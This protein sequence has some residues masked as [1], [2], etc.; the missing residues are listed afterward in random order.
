MVREQAVE[1]GLDLTLVEARDL[2]RCGEM[3]GGMWR[4]GA[5]PDAGRGARSGEM[6][7]GMGLDLTLVEARDWARAAENGREWRGAGRGCLA[8]RGA[9][10]GRAPRK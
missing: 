1:E 3:W 4:Y 8:T 9:G 2:G 6:W 10:E 5:R 7:G